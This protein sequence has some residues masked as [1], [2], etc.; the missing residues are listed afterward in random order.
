MSPAK[1]N[2][3]KYVTYIFE[4]NRIVHDWKYQGTQ[5]RLSENR[6]NFDRKFTTKTA[7]PVR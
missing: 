7:D 3:F 6:K 1:S 2:C 4:E 5:D